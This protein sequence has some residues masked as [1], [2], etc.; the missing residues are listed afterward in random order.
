[1]QIGVQN[2]AFAQRRVLLR[3]R[4]LDLDDLLRTDKDFLGCGAQLGAGRRIPLVEQ[5]GSAN[6][7]MPG[8]VY[9]KKFPSFLRRLPDN[10]K[11]VVGHSLADGNATTRYWLSAIK[12]LLCDARTK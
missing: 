11:R 4:F 8:T 5:A 2:L 7:V 12:R 6:A 10:L 9:R 3:L 1:M